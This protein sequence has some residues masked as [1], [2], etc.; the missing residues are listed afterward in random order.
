MAQ[1]ILPT[2]VLANMER[3]RQVDLRIEAAQEFNRLLKE[4]DPR[5]GLVRAH[6]RADAP[7]LIPGYWHVRR[8]N[9]PPA[10]DTYMPITGPHGEFMEPHTGVLEEL[11]YADL[12]NGGLERIIEA[13]ARARDARTREEDRQREDRVGQMADVIHTLDTPSIRVT[14]KF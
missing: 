7:G 10:A 3:E 13:Q 2:H 6:E 11:R 1:I 9:A 4:I 5:L 14:K 12:H 8:R